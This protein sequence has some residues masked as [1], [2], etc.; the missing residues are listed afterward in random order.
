MDKIDTNK[1]SKVAVALSGGLDSSVACWLLKQQNYDVIAVTAKML[2]DQ[3]FEQIT[4]NAKNVA[5]KI[6]IA[7]YVIDLSK[8]FKKDVIDYFEESYKTG[9]TPNPCIMCNRTIKWGKLFDYAINELKCD[10]VASGHYAKIVDD[11]GIKKLYPAKDILKDQQYYLFEL[12]QKQLNKIIVPLSEYTKDDIRKIAIEND[13][14]SKSSKESQDICFITKPMTTKKYI[15]QKL[16]PKNGNF[17]LSTTGEKIG[18][19]NGFFQYTIGQ[20][21]GIGIA[22]S[23]PLYVTKLDA[24]NN[25]VYVGTKDELYTDSLVFNDLSLQY[26]FKKNEFDA[27]VKIRYNMSAKKAKVI[28]DRKNNCGEIKFYEPVSAITA[29]QAVV[30]Y[31]LD[32]NHLVGGGWIK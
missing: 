23:E 5:Q 6:G 16:Q 25:I 7:H 3:K 2:N 10:F 21:K 27:N 24:K 1:K 8:E 11:N 22:H 12:Q 9:K 20:R 14:P 15:S 4:E 31:S 18:T 30:F 19:H 28:L 29:G 17:I 26:P 32:D 13:L